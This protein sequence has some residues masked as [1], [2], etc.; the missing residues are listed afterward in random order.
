MF[1]EL[2][3]ALQ[4][5]TIPLGHPKV[6]EQPRAPIEISGP[7]WASECDGSTDRN[8]PAPPVR[9]HANTYLVGT[10][11][12]SAIY[13]VGEDGDVL[14]DGGEEGDADLIADNIRQLGYWP[15]RIR[16]ILHSDADSAHLGGIA[17]L[18]RISGATVVASATASKMLRSGLSEG[19]AKE[20]IPAVE[21]GRIITDGGEV[22]LGNLLLTAIASSD[23]GLSWRWESCA[24]GV[25]R[26]MVY[27]ATIAPG[28]SASAARLSASRCEILVSSIPAA[29][30]M[31]K[32]L[33][34]GQ[35]LFDA[36]A[37]KIYAA[38]ASQPT[39]AEPPK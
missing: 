15:G 37:C 39:P 32:R 30:D 6:I 19:E 33:V 3:L 16:F 35:P 34:L 7:L 27:A 26:T 5:I 4:G 38:G 13:I 22:R 31:R 36:D 25:C 9:I 28:D 17:K 8:K 11:G 14:I 24:V 29:S 2:L 1:A 12:L 23:G 21:V 18:Q 20:T 10:C